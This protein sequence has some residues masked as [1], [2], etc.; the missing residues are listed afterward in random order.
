M[1][2]LPPNLISAIKLI[3]PYTPR[4]NGKVERSHREDQKRFY[5]CHSFYSLDDFAKQ[6]A[7]HNRR[8]NNFPMRP[9]GWLSPQSSPSICLTN[10][11]QLMLLPGRM[12][13]HCRPPTSF[14]VKGAP[15]TIR[16]RT[17][18]AK[19][20]PGQSPAGFL[21]PVPYRPI[22]LPRTGRII[23]CT[24]RILVRRFRCK[25]LQGHGRH[26]P[27]SRALQAS[28]RSHCDKSSAGSCRRQ[29]R[30]FRR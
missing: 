29:C 23:P 5:S 8:S 17:K 14:S 7:I 26:C 15:S 25:R 21:L 3:R 19:S 22:P 2:P 6:L 9:L 18:T 10:L 28:S 1:R 27:C 4:H 24:A 20:P 30:C 16:R 11:Q 13:V 12:K